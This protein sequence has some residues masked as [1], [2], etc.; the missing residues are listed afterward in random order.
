MAGWLSSRTL[1]SLTISEV[2]CSVR[3][4]QSLDRGFTEL[5]TCTQPD[6]LRLVFQSIS[7]HPVT[8][9]NNISG[10]PLNLVHVIRG[11]STDFDL[12][13]VGV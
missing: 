9:A 8:D 6:N 7:G 10:E 3:Q 13:V 11:C 12:R 5:L 4:S 1:R 2:H